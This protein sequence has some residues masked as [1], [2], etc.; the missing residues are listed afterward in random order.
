LFYG[1]FLIAIKRTT[2]TMATT[3]IIA[4][5]TPMMVML[6]SGI[7]VAGCGEAVGAAGA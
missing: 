3:I 2:P 5:L 6:L 4:A 1:R 7:V